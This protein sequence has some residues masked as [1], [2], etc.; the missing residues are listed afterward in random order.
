MR[1]EFPA[2]YSMGMDQGDPGAQPPNDSKRNAPKGCAG[3]FFFSALL[4]AAVWGAGLGVFVWIIEDDA[5][6]TMRALDNFRPKIGSKV[7]STGGELLGEF[8]IESR[9]V[10]SLNEMPL[11]LQLSFIATEDDEFYNHKGVRPLAI[12]NAAFDALRTS[13]IRGASTITQ[14]TVRN[15]EQTGISTEVTIKRKFKEAVFALQLEREY[16]KDEILEIY[17]NQI[18]LGISAHGVE[19][20]ARQYYSKSVSELTLSEC[21]ALAGLTRAP[22]T[23]QPFKNPDFTLRR[24]DIVLA[25]MLKN[26]FITREEHDAALAEDLDASVVTPEERKAMQGD[27]DTAGL[28]VP[29]KFKAPYFVEEVRKF[30]GRPP[31][32]YEVNAT[33]DELFEGGLEIFTTIDLRIQEAGERI[34]GNA[35]DEFDATKRAS[36]KRQGLE[37][38]FV[39]VSGALICLDN[40]EGSQG[41]IRA[42]VGG[43]NFDERK[44]NMVTQALRQPGSSVKPFVWL[45][46]IDNGMTASSII[47]DE[48]FTRLDGA[49]NPWTPKNFEDKFQ[50]PV[51]LRFA[52]EKS[53]N[54]VSIKLV[55]KFGL[56]LVRSYMQ[57][58]GFRQPI[59]DV[60]NL[61]LGLGTPVTTVL[62]Q[63]VCYSTLALGGVRVAPTM[64]T[65]IKDRDGIVRYDYRTF[66]KKEPLL[67]PDACYAVVH[68][69]EGVCQED[70]SL[71]HYPS[72]RR[73]ERLGR[74]RA[75]KTGT[76]N[77]SKDAWF[78]GFTP[79]FTCVVWLGYEDSRPL[80]R[81]IPYTG[82]ALASPIWTDF[83]IEAHEGLP[84]KEFAVPPGVE[85]HNIHRLTGLAGGP[86]REAYIRGAEPPTEMPILDSYGEIESL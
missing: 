48:F 49:G 69:M 9:H 62:D 13:R 22:N 75:G 8:A 24:R 23:N 32:P 40:R 41:F 76:T 42:M 29:G 34:L 70:R 26:K 61:T 20:A 84:V 63:A 11:K 78:C 25:Q 68:M 82:G 19:S 35:L 6:K 43:R 4:V 45:T 65:E 52:L 46:A 57:D 44:F 56:P 37:D 81:G 30:I 21:A 77:F 17:L 54:I 58:A 7:Y 28:L 3:L 67:S 15:I 55:E 60:V 18:F 39:P 74:P 14:Q 16:T 12:L 71:E 27:R 47:V 50:G 66:S 10:V 5:G 53:I 86:Y 38:E 36:L 73:T 31:A 79:Q 33:Q 64:I 59:D 51:P 2:W 72:G 85:F 1:F 80:G 83:M